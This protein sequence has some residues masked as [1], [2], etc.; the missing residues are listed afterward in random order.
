M[1]SRQIEGMKA[2]VKTHW[3]NEPCE[4]RY[5]SSDARREYFDEIAQTRYQLQPYIPTFAGFDKARGLCILEIG[6]G[7]GADFHNWIKN[8][9]QAT[10]IDMTE[11][12]I[13]LTTERLE[14]N[15]V[16]TATYRLMVADA[17]N[18]P[19]ESEQFDLVYAFGVLHHTPDTETAFREVH[20]V[21]KPGGMLRAMVYHV[22]SW[23]GWML[24]VAH[25]LLKAKPFRSPRQ[26]I[27]EHLESPGT[28]AYTV[29][30]AGDLLNRVGFASAQVTTQL[31][32]G[33]LLLIKPSERYQS[34]SAKIAWALH[35]R[36]L[37]KLL[38]NR[39]GLNLM[40]HANKGGGDH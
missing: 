35:P 39:F 33:D 22:P 38:G 3:E 20:R 18:L 26:V 12:A 17:E 9:G 28:K 7:A 29:R 25:G 19:F 2:R 31:C 16:D 40:I 21:L 11:A 6:V 23:V 4:S 37:V 30:E 24:W 14:L 10:G 15:H 36:W 8:G 34:T 5:G 32:P 13:A 1:V 27:Y